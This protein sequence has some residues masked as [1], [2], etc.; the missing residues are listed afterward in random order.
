MVF[1]NF[2]Q[3]EEL[4]EEEIVNDPKVIPIS[5]EVY[6]VLR[7]GDTLRIRDAYGRIVVIRGRY[8][9]GFTRL[10]MFILGLGLGLLVAVLSW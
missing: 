5:A 8:A 2:G 1:I 9:T 4:F 10:A 3:Q 7:P 6:E